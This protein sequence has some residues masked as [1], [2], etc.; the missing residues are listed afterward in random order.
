MIFYF[1]LLFGVPAGFIYALRPVYI[2]GE[3]T[4]R[5]RWY[6]YAVA[7][8]GFASTYTYLLCIKGV[9]F[10]GA[11]EA[12]I[13]YFVLALVIFLPGVIVGLVLGVLARIMRNHPKSAGSDL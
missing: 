13:A 8:V 9:P 10:V 11:V 6:T 1:G 7:L 3:L 2:A 4:L 12:Y 5:A